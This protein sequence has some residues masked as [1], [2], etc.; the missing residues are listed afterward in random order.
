L[1]V[2]R[3]CIDYNRGWPIKAEEW[4]TVDN[5]L[6]NDNSFRFN[7]KSEMLAVIDNFTENKIGEEIEV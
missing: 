6:M 7:E 2:A 4:V 1:K 3:E 5:S